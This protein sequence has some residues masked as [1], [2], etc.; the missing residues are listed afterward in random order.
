[1]IEVMKEKGTF[2]LGSLFQRVSFY[3]KVIVDLT[4]ALN[5]IPDGNV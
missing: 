2:V 1:M 3:G 4:R 5:I